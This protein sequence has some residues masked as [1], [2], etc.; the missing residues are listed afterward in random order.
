MIGRSHDFSKMCFFFNLDYWNFCLISF[1]F[2]TTGPNN[3]N[4]TGWDL[5]FYKTALKSD[6]ISM[7]SWPFFV[8][9]TPFK[10]ILSKSYHDIIGVFIYWCNL[11]YKS[12]RAFHM[13]W[14]FIQSFTDPYQ[15]WKGAV[16]TPL[17]SVGCSK[18]LFLS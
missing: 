2:D 4:S 1:D 9:S 5:H 16:A 13:A 8:F 10:K 12:R 18:S 17:G 14:H 7:V 6:G 15:K 11:L 3:S